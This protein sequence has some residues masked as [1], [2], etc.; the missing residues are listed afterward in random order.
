MKPLI[1]CEEVWKPIPT[2]EGI[3]EISN[4]GR[5]RSLS[6]EEFVEGRHP[7]GVLRRR[8]EKF[9]SLREGLY[10]TVC[11]YKNGR[12]RQFT[13][14]RLVAL[15]FLGHPPE[16][17]TEVNHLDEDRHNNSV[18]NLE[19]TTRRGNALHSSYKQRG[20]RSSTAKLTEKDVLEIKDLL[21]EGRLLQTE[22]AKIYGVSNHAIFRIKAGDNWAWLTG[23]DKEGTVHHASINRY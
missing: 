4:L 23:F 11:L 8:K 3:Y 14:H 15:I 1:D 13:V 10:K 12:G 19:W 7:Q 17:M 22:I 21:Q 6:R 18:E 16:G 5:I 2:Y 20:E 9:L